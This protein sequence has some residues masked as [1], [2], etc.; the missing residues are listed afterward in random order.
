MYYAN[1]LCLMTF[2]S[3]FWS[4]NTE[5]FLKWNPLSNCTSIVPTKIVGWQ[6]QK[7][8]C[9]FMFHILPVMHNQVCTDYQNGSFLPHIIFYLFT[10]IH[11]GAKCVSG[12]FLFRDKLLSLSFLKLMCFIFISP[13]NFMHVCVFT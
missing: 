4:F 8:T 3:T 5:H 12:L 9:I 10:L 11:L 2:I 1:D 13:I 6:V 7:S